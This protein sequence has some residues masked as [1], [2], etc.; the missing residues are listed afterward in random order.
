MLY[1]NSNNKN[2]LKYNKRIDCY[3]I[4]LLQ[5]ILL[6]CFSMS[7]II[8]GLKITHLPS[9]KNKFKLLLPRSRLID[10]IKVNKALIVFA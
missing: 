2:I 6:R 8:S 1:R 4:P 7:F 10:L 3:S 5:A 9:S